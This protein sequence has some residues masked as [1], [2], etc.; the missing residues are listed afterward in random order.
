MA[1]NPDTTS[2]RAGFLDRQAESSK[3]DGAARIASTPPEELQSLVRSLQLRQRELERENEKLRAANLQSAKSHDR[4]FRL[5]T[6]TIQDVFWISKPGVSQQ[7]YVSPAYEAIWGRSVDECM[8]RPGSFMESIHSE[9]REKYA[10]ILDECHAGGRSYSCEYRIVR[11]DGSVRWISERGFPIADDDGDV[12]LMTGVCTDITEQKRVL[13]ALRES[14]DRYRRVTEGTSGV[15]YTYAADSGGAYYSSNVAQIL[16]HSR[17]SLL[18]QPMLWHDSIH[19]DDVGHVDEILTSMAPGQTYEVEYRIQRASGDWIWLRDRFSVQD[20]EPGAMVV[21]G[22]AVDVTETKQAE[23]KLRQSEEQYR[24]I[25][26][27]TTDGLAI[28]DQLGTFVEVNPAFCSMHGYSRD[29]LLDFAAQGVIHPDSH[30]LFDR[31]VESIRRGQP[32][33]SEAKDVRKDATSFDVEVRGVPFNYRGQSHLLAILRDNTKRKHAEEA[34]R[35]LN[36]ELEARVHERTATLNAMVAELKDEAARRKRAEESLNERAA[37]LAHFSRV[38]T[39]GEM[40]SGLAHELNQP[41]VAISL[42][43]EICAAL[44]EREA[45][46]NVTDELR[47]TFQEIT[48][49]AQRAGRIVNFLRNFVSDT[50]PHRSTNDIN[51]VVNGILR[52]FEAE[53]RRGRVSIGCELDDNLPQTMIDRIQIEQVIINLLRNATEATAE[54]DPGDRNVVI[55]TSPGPSGEIHVSI[56]DNGNG[57]AAADLDKVFQGFFTTKPGGMGLGLSICRSIVEAHH[58]RLWVARN[59]DR[60]VTFYFSVSRTGTTVRKAD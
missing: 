25:F 40:A 15:V 48:E 42:Q 54:N 24:G 41:L 27:A 31:F 35:R 36:E 13:G 46:G 23:Q 59:A 47:G 50:T 45:G 56:S 28:L 22:V 3:T 1:E 26:E 10:S 53:A 39:A 32:F 14:Q 11:P 17:K 21:D 49:Q 43:S 37:Q 30:P 6:E 38:S 60:G 55:K 29:E 44:L 52:I 18:S 51:D 16:G 5:V 2:D 9:D 57:I 34:L 20:G 4:R 8:E 12:E 33:Y 19:P 58:G 7:V